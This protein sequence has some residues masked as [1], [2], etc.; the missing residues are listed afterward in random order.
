MTVVAR[1]KKINP[2]VHTQV[3]MCS[4]GDDYGSDGEGDYSFDY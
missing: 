4:G 1:H 3:R 2:F